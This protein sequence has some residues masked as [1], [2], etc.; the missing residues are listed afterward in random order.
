MFIFAIIDSIFLSLVII[1]G[2]FLCK[3]IADENPRNGIG[4]LKQ[5]IESITDLL[6]GVVNSYGH[7]ST[8]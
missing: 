5:T 7:I 3:S 8:A 6:L 1:A 4:D 2:G